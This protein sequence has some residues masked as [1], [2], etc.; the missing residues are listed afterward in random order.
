MVVE[1]INNILWGASYTSLLKDIY[2]EA[3]GA[4]DDAL[5]HLTNA[6]SLLDLIQTCSDEQLIKNSR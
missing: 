2:K 4:L 3:F 1:R 5:G 6:Q